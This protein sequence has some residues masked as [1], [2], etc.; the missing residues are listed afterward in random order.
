MISYK[1]VFLTFVNESQVDV[2]I[3]HG[4][5]YSNP[6]VKQIFTLIGVGAGAH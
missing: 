5:G 1:P 2:V 4:V 3:E 6:A